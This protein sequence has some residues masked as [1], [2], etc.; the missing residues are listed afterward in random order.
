MTDSNRWRPCDNAIEGRAAESPPVD[1][2]GLDLDLDWL[3]PS[4]ALRQGSGAVEVVQR[5]TT[6]VKAPYAP[7][8]LI[9]FFVCSNPRMLR[10]RLKL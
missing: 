2:A 10:T 9:A 5:A 8:S 6:D 4:H 1:I 3:R 7:S